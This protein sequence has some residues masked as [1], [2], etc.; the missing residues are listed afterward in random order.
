MATVAGEDVGHVVGVTVAGDHNEHF[1]R[2]QLDSLPVQLLIQ[3]VF[4]AG[5]HDARL[6]E[7]VPG[8]GGGSNPSGPPEHNGRNPE[9]CSGFLHVCTPP[10]DGPTP[11]AEVNT[12]Y[13]R[14]AVVLRAT[15]TAN[16][17]QL[18]FGTVQASLP[19]CSLLG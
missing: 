6:V 11:H 16:P 17:S 9:R 1:S 15:G 19:W 5:S 14:L 13:A 4:L 7:L 2:L 10:G 3:L 12:R 8:L 18:H